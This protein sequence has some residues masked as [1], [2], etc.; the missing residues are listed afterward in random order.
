MADPT[1]VL[2]E[3]GAFLRQALARTAAEREPISGFEPAFE[4]PDDSPR[5]TEYLDVMAMRF[6]PL[7]TVGRTGLVLLD[8]MANPATRTVKTLASHVIVAR[9]VRHTET[10][11][12]PVLILTPSSANK[13]TA[14]RDA[15]LRAYRTGLTTPDQLRIVALVPNEARAKLWSSP[16]CD[17][18]ALAAAEVQAHA[19]GRGDRQEHAADGSRHQRID[20]AGLGNSSVA[21]AGV[22]DVRQ[23][24]RIS[25]RDP[26]PFRH[27]WSASPS[28]VWIPWASAKSRVDGGTDPLVITTSSSASR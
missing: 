26:P 9:A 2:A 28:M 24:M 20:D 15:V 8:L 6:A 4:L 23:R 5:L 27:R 22:G 16:L 10:T 12:E 17:D 19:P 3:Y 25:S 18:A 1:D 7:G 14:L 13:A 21:Q 11:G